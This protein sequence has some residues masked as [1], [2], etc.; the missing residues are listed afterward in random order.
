MAIRQWG[1]DCG[2]PA[3]YIL[4]DRRDRKPVRPLAFRLTTDGSWGRTKWN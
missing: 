3:D 1:E 2:G 4:V